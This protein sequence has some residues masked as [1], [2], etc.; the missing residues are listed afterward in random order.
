VREAEYIE[1]LLSRLGVGK[2]SEILDLGCGNGR[3]A[4][5]LA[6]K[7]YRV[8]GVDISQLF[9][10]D[11]RR[12]AKEHGVAD[13]TEFLI[14]SVFELGKILGERRVDA[15][16]LYWTTILGY[17]HDL[18]SNIAMLKEIWKVTKDDGYLLIL[19]TANYE[20]A[21]SRSGLCGTASYI[22]EI[23]EELVLV[24][25]PV[26]DHIRA[27]IK[28][29][30]IFYK[31]IVRDLKYI[32]EVEIEIRLFTPHELVDIAGRAGWIFVEA[33]PRPRYS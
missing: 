25:K 10:E 1:K 20:L 7:G 3:I 28:S 14:G 22:E 16:I 12:R 9:I 6:V 30:W 31:K 33:F 13:L 23:D 29:R 26:L 18:D 5:N 4:I 32:D 17:H 11:A 21:A 19:N 15:T 2:N 24:E 27:T 8:I